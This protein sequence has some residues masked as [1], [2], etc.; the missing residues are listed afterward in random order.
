MP[1]IDWEIPQADKI[2][3]NGFIT[4]DGWNEKLNIFNHLFDPWIL[5]EKVIQKN[6]KNIEKVFKIFLKTKN[7]QLN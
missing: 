6:I 4:S 1:F 7:K 3:K 2:K 5:S